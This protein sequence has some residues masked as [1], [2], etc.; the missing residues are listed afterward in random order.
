M[1][2]LLQDATQSGDDVV[3]ALVHYVVGVM[4]VGHGHSKLV[5]LR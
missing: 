4:P 3:Q 2:L 1:A 5:T